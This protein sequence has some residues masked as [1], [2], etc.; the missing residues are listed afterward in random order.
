MSPFCQTRS[1]VGTNVR[2]Y[3]QWHFYWVQTRWWVFPV[4]MAQ[5][6]EPACSADFSW[7][8]L[9]KIKTECNTLTILSD[10][11]QS[12]TITVNAEMPFFSTSPEKQTSNFLQFCPNVGDMYGSWERPWSLLS[13]F[14]LLSWDHEKI[15]LLSWNNGS[16]SRDNRIN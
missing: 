5:N 7:W 10:T 8:I 11:R 14:I 2:A 3:W 4:I 9:Q 6:F 13:L 12:T 15:I 16:F 1:L